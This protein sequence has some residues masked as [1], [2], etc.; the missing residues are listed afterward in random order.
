MADADDRHGLSHTNEG[1]NFFQG[2]QGFS[3]N[4]QTNIGQ[5]TIVRHNLIR[6]DGGNSLLDALDPVLDASYTR[7]RQTSPPDSNCLPGTREDVIQTVSTWADSSKLNSTP[8]LMWLYGYVGCGKSAIAQTVAE[9]YAA[10][11]RLAASFFFFRGSGHRSRMGKFVATIASQVATAI[12]STGKVIKAALKAHAGLLRPTT[13][14]GTQLQH[15]LFGPLKSVSWSLHGLNLIC[16]GPFLIVLDGLDE[17]EDR[18]A[19]TLL[20]EHLLGFFEKNPRIPL[21]VF[22]T[23]RVEEHIRTR[24]DTSSQVRLL[25]LVDHTSLD[26]IITALRILFD[27]AAQHSRVIQAYGEWPSPTELHLLA[28]HTGCSFIFMS[29]IA[30]FILGDSRSAHSPKERL[31]LALNINPGLDGLYSQ[32]LSRAEHLAHFSL[33]I[34]TIALVR[35]PLSILELADLL[36]IQKFEV[37]QVLVQMHSILQVPG[38][39]T[40]Q[41]TLCHSSLYDFLNNPGRSNRFHVDPWQH[42]YLATRCGDIFGDTTRNAPA[43][44]YAMGSRT[45]H[46]Q[47]S[48]QEDTHRL[49]GYYT[50]ILSLAE[51]LPHFSLILSTITLVETPLSILE[52]ADLLN[53]ETSQVVRALDPIQSVLQ[54][55]GNLPIIDQKPTFPI[56][57]CH[58][59]LRH[60]LTDPK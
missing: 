24:L 36:N 44:F 13:S 8:H 28:E 50:K 10:D 56:I 49:D 59:S 32:T 43:L 55:P 23:S 22:I 35:R 57:L 5:Q 34:S 27:L 16:G 39:D 1:T 6:G 48:P 42:I 58:I 47:A 40:T 9:K 31:P 21:R 60:F 51:H 41:V 38:D 33:I 14:L 19:I 15:L 46:W 7:N 30:K 37:I 12:P 26:D 4:E 53:I 52:L 25:N 54:I 18:E 2:A 17:C 3:I 29:T 11:G 20:V 45:Y